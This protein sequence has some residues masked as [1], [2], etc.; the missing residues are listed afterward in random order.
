MCSDPLDRTIAQGW[1]TEDAKGR[2]GLTDEGRALFGKAAALQDEL[3]AER[4]A[5]VS[6]EDYLITL[7][8]L[9]RFIHNT[10]G[11]AWHH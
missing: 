2:L 5:D 3:W 10:S 11:R 8:M 1:I 7:K 4:H 9:Q 6:D